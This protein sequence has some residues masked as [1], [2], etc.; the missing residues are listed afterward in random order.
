M[1]Y[2]SVIDTI[3]D[4]LLALACASAFFILP[5][6]GT[7]GRTGQPFYLL[8]GIASIGFLYKCLYLPSYRISVSRV[9]KEYGLP[10]FFFISLTSLNLFFYALAHEFRSSALFASDF[11]RT[12]ALLL[13]FLIVVSQ[14]S[15]GWKRL[16]WLRW[17]WLIPLVLAPALFIGDIGAF[18][19]TQVI[20]FFGGYK[21]QAFQSEDPTALSTWLLITFALCATSVFSTYYR[22]SQRIFFG[23]ASVITMALIW[24]SNSRGALFAAAAILCVVAVLACRTRQIR[25]SMATFLAIFILIC[26]FLILPDQAKTSV[27]VRFYP[28]YYASAL[29]QNFRVPADSMFRGIF[30]DTPSFTS[31][32]NRGQL[33]AP[34]P[35]DIASHP[36]GE[37]GPELFSVRTF[38]GQHNSLFQAAFW[39]GWV[40]FIVIGWFFWRVIR[41][42]TGL[43]RLRPD[44]PN[45]LWLTLAFSGVLL[46]SL[47]NSFLQFKPLWIIAALLVAYERTRQDS[48]ELS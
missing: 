18:I 11:Y 17:S 31:A 27:F 8:L 12:L 47:L 1:R 30:S 2:I 45:S 9:L 38:C 7:G 48:T 42:G 44:D 23:A 3:I 25:P 21:L 40:A 15:T 22:R 6:L 5:G 33:W 14:V 39:G 20:P 16:K 26:G 29:A 4:V 34:C 28:Q 32:Q 13:F 36:L 19:Q 41:I 24:W 10:L 43:I 35:A 46:Q 37:F